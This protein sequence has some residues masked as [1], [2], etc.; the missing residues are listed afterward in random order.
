MF[1]HYLQRKVEFFL[2]FNLLPQYRMCCTYRVL[3][4]NSMLFQIII[5]EIVILAV[6]STGTATLKA[7]KAN[8]NDC[9]H[10]EKF[11]SFVLFQTLWK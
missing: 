1:P 2:N 6:C 5:V 4:E 3:V 10:T 8:L 9:E 7:E 11:V